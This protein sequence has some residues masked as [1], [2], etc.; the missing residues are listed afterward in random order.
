[1]N[2]EERILAKTTL[3][4]SNHSEQFF[5]VYHFNRLRF[6]IAT[7]YDDRMLE[8]CE[9]TLEETEGKRGRRGIK[10][11]LLA[12]YDTYGYVYWYDAITG[13]HSYK[14]YGWC[15]EFEEIKERID[16]GF[17]DYLVVLNFSEI[18]NKNKEYF[19]R[20]ERVMENEIGFI[21]S[22]SKE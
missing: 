2:L 16:G 22:T 15:H 3:T 13:Q 5:D 20:F 21:I 10:I 8:F 17:C 4:P 6:G 14:Y 12:D 19:D 1:M 7:L 18:Y 9:Y 11:P